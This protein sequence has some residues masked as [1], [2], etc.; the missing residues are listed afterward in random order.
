MILEGF[1]EC[2]CGQ[3]TSIAPQTRSAQGHVAGRP[4]RFVQG[5]SGR[6][7][8][9]PILHGRMQCSCCSKWRALAEFYLR[10]AGQG[11]DSHCIRCRNS[12]QRE[13]YATDPA[14]RAMRR[15]DETRRQARLRGA[16]AAEYVDPLVV[17]ERADGTCGICGQDVDPFAFE[18]DHIVPLVHHGLHNYANTQP[19]HPVCNRLK[20][21]T[22]P[23]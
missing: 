13:R 21:A 9:R 18:V 10:S 6:A 14:Y 20:G 8:P 4:V 17:L 23:S 2:G 1:C 12:A 7:T 3:A 22:C 11:R 5:H 19:A 16:S 15:A